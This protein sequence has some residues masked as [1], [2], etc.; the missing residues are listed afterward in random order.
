[1]IR[2]TPAIRL[3]IGLIVLVVSILLL[4]QAL[5]LTSGTEK[6]QFEIRKQTAETLAAQINLAVSRGD[7]GL[8]RDLMN[9]AIERNADMQSAAIRKTDGEV[10]IETNNHDEFWKGAEAKVSTPTHMRFPMII[11]SVTRAN[12]EITFKPLTSET[13][14]LFHIP[15]FIVLIIFVVV[16]GFI[17]FWLYIRRVLKHLDPSA[18][19]PA[20]VRNALNILAEGVLILDKREHIV[21]ANTSILE[22][23]N[24]SEQNLV[25][26]KASSL[27]WQLIDNKNSKE[28]PW[29]TAL[30]S[31]TKQVNV[32]LA[33]PN[34][35]QTKTF[36]VNAVPILDAKGSS[37]GTI[38]VFDDITELEEKRRQLEETVKELAKSRT[39][40]E[41][42]NKELTFLATRDPL[43]NCFNRR[44]LYEYLEGKAAGSLKPNTDYACIM[45][46]IDHFKRVNDTHG[47][48]VGD[49][50]IKT[51]ANTIKE[52]VR[53][54][55]IVARMGGEEFCI[56]LPNTSLDVARNIAE[57][58][59]E[60]ISSKMTRGVKVT[61]SFGVTSIALGAKDSAT[62]IHQ[63]DEALYA[64]KENGRN[65]VTSWSTSITSKGG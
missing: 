6:Q 38:A 52:V 40:I 59:R 46:D 54:K 32:H 42:K 49:A 36:R 8:I 1:M 35:E 50:V 34:G 5:G 60:S 3:S 30:S 57:R 39:A 37:Q 47:H 45:A 58:C 19:V 22:N 12:T 48:G 2:I 20:R 14:P 55:D 10:L 51:M 15:T 4:A 13:H 64:S 44:A 28:F 63:A 61:A 62:I 23:L 53:E 29:L 9:T 43:T 31:N 16:S 56:I 27:G 24:K 26:K 25:G 65:R 21:L 7:D 11:N 18:V 17:G 41:S 33:L